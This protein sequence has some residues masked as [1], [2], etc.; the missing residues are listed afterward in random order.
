MLDAKDAKQVVDLL[1]SLHHGVLAMSP[2][3]PGLV[4]DSTNLATVSTNDD[5][6]EIVTSQRSAIES[7]KQAAA[8]MVATTCRLAGFEVE[9]SG[10]YPGWKP[11]PN[12]EIVRKL[13]AAHEELF[14]QPAKLI[15]MHAGLECGVIGEKYPG[16]ADGVIRPHHCGS[17]QPGRARAN[18]H[19][20]ELLVV[21]QESARANL[22]MLSLKIEATAPSGHG[23]ENKRRNKATTTGSG[24]NSPGILASHFRFLTLA[25]FLLLGPLL[26][27]ADGKR[28]Y[29]ERCAGCHGSDARGSGKGPGLAGN[30]R[31]SG[32]SAEQLAG[33][34]K[35]GFPASGMPAFPLPADEL[36]AVASY[37]HGLNAGAKSA[38]AP[39]GKRLTWG[40]PQPGDWLTYNGKAQREPL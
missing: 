4:Q 35:R 13:Q 11:E 22:R 6:V 32:Q 26:W 25:T 5:V 7:S 12:S 9:Q 40:K 23:S 8:R 20:G 2:D 28:V 17:A 19:G 38:P 21:S 24:Q 16:H 34:V 37:V 14:G 39:A 27:S 10:S 18:L 29:V 15:A 30:P 31:L 33:V 3:V 1:A 36:Q